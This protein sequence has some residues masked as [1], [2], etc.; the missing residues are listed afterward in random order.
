[1]WPCWMIHSLSGIAS[2][3]HSIRRQRVL[4]KPIPVDDSE[5]GDVYNYSSWM[6]TF[7][8]P[9]GRITV[10]LRLVAMNSLDVKARMDQT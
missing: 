3:Y 9:V 5:L 10:T 2:E 8:Q 7:L 4:L 1:M 6:L